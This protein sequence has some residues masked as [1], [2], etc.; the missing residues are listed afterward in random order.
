MDN[1][2][3]CVHRV[4]TLDWDG[5]RSLWAEVKEGKTPEWPDGKAFVEET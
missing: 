4:A 1:A 3:A 5:L 2:S